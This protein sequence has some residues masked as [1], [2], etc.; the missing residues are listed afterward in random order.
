MATRALLGGNR[1]LGA[2]DLCPQHRHHG[3]QI[4]DTPRV[5]HTLF[6]EDLLF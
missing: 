6:N 5:K 1:G 3:M 2:G 4:S